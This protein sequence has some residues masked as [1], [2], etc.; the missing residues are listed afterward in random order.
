MLQIKISMA[1]RH[2]LLNVKLILIVI[3]MSTAKFTK[4]DTKLNYNV[5]HGTYLKPLHY[6][7]EI[8]FDRNIF[9]AK[10]NI[11]IQTNRPTRNITMMNSKIFG[12]ARFDLINN[13][14]NQIINFLKFSFINKTYLH[15]DFNQ[16]SID[17]LYSGTYIIKMTYVSNIDDGD[18]FESFHMKEKYEI[19]NK[20]IRA[21]EL[22][23]YFDEPVFKST[24]NISI[25][26]HKS[27]TF[28][29][30][31]PI[32]KQVEDMDNMMWTQFDT[33][34]SM[35][36]KYLTIVMTT[37]NYS[38][39]YLTS[40]TIFKFWSRKEITEQVRYA[41][42]ITQGV[43]RYLAQKNTR[44]ISKIDYI[45][46]NDFQDSNIKTPGFILLREEDIRYNN[47]LH[48]VRKIEVA[49]LI[50][51]ETI[52]Y[53]HNDVFLWS[54]EGFITFLAAHILDQTRSYYRMVDLFVVQTQQEYLRFQTLPINSLLFRSIFQYIKSSIIWRILYHILS[55]TVFWTSINTYI[56]IQYNQINATDTNNSSTI[57]SFW[58]VVESA[59]GITNSTRNFNIQNVV[60]IWL[61]KRHCPILYVTRN[62]STNLVS[63]S[64]INSNNTLFSD[65]KQYEIYVVY[66]TKS[67]M[68]IE[69]H[70]FWL[71]TLTPYHYISHEIDN[72][73]WIILNLEQVG[74][75]RVNYHSD[76]WQKLAHCLYYENYTN[77]HV[78]NR[79]Q[80]IDD[81]VYFLTHRHQLNFTMFW[82]ITSFLLKDTDYVAWYP[83]IKAVE[84]MTC[85]W[86]VQNTASIKWPLKEK[87]Y[88]LLHEIGYDDKY[89]ESDFTKYLREEAVKWACVLD[90]YKCRQTA[91]FQLEKH[92]ESSAEDKLFKK[93]WI[94]CKGLMTS[95][96]LTWNKVWNK[97]KATSDNTFLEYLTCS[98]DLFI[99]QNYLELIITDRVFNNATNSKRNANL[100]LLIVA[101]HA[102]NSIVLDYI[103]SNFEFLE[104]SLKKQMDQIA[105]LIVII[106]H[107]H[108]ENQ[109][110]KITAFIINNDNLVHKNLVNVIKQKIRK[111]IFE[112]GK[113]VTNYGSTGSTRK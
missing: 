63:I 84:Y 20:V 103:F 86:P 59:L 41:I 56:D 75:Y 91:A 49:N 89:D 77:I 96:L 26:H 22:F 106:T 32:Q 64:Y 4:N 11:T 36:A 87:F 105:I 12:V 66:T 104:F 48:P 14:S 110:R 72:D 35:P 65:I 70:H 92:L 50:A 97:W 30:S 85:I 90:V 83:M 109:F 102:K 113:R 53:W 80:I 81:T 47:T 9:S 74:D 8:K 67:L 107:E 82:D 31:I 38:L 3:I 29:S 71:S 88:K 15:L 93:E 54:K 21:G 111:R 112:Y 52:S 6:D 61:T 43:V 73:D 94:Y 68:N 79:A 58:D 1:F 55:D 23:P 69:T 57:V 17:L 60:N 33:S 100:F 28:L 18:F 46:T 62:Y 40:T 16:S 44:K 27:Y 95:N 45:V 76:Y 19:L 37:Y 13:N 10:C 24:F 99:I 101:K 98:T 34:P 42:T 25:K 7:V 5:L 51:R 39:I 108:N 78:L 2:I